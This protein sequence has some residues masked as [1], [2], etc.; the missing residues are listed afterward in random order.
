MSILTNIQRYFYNQSLDKSRKQSRQVSKPVSF[1][2][3]QTI[4]ILFDA[5]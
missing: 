3:A 1:E 5:T 2:A 4:G